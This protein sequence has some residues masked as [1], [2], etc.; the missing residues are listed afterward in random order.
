MFK[1]DWQDLLSEVVTKFNRMDNFSKPKRKC[2]HMVNF[3]EIQ[4]GN[5]NRKSKH[6]VNFRET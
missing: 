2:T 6:I 4:K 3:R 5:P 1:Q